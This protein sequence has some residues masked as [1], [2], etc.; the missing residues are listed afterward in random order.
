MGWFLSNPNDALAHFLKIVNK[1]LDKHAPYKTIKYSKIR[2]ETKP[3]ITPGL[4]NSMRNKLYESFCKEIDPKIKEYYEK[5]FKSNRNHLS[6]LLRKTKDSY[7]KQ[8]FEDKKENLRLVWPI[9]KGII[10]TKK[11]SDE[12]IS[13]L[14]IDGQIITS[15]KE[16]CNYFN[17]FLTSV[18]VKINKKN[19]QVK[20]KKNTYPTLAMKTVTLFSFLQ[21]YQRILKT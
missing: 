14:L 19:C 9:I 13:S 18:A 8:Y 21:L 10:N 17:N 4:A 3:W 6:S 20:N 5:Q 11:K 15:A 12:S 2:Y 1:L 7:F 16:I